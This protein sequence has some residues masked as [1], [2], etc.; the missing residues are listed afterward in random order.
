M[1]ISQTDWS[2]EVSDGWTATDHPECL[3][4]E[5]SGEG[6]LQLSSA[7]KKSGIVSESELF[8]AEGER[9]D[10]GFWLRTTCGDFDGVRYE[11][12]EGDVAWRRWFLRR[13]RTILFITYNGTLTGAATERE[14]VEQMLGS[15]KAESAA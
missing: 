6:A 1:R 15:L 9:Q 14:A 13:E 5:R 3:T 12:M 2:I 10:W 7:R 4:L 11:Y 8:F